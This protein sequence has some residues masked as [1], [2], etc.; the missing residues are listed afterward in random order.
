[1]RA[2]IAVA[3]GV[4]EE[5]NAEEFGDQYRE[6]E[7]EDPYREQELPKGFED[8]KSNLILRCVFIPV[9]Q[10]QPIGLFIKLYNVYCWNMVG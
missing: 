5:E 4:T 6:P 10:T 7:P 1:M 8:G 3:D 2:V 9:L